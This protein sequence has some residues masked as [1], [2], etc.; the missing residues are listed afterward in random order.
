MQKAALSGEKSWYLGMAYLKLG[1]FLLARQ[2]FENSLG[3]GLLNGN[4]KRSAEEN[5]ESFGKIL[6]AYTRI[7]FS[8]S[9]HFNARR[10]LIAETPFF[11]VCYSFRYFTCTLLL[12][13]F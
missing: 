6:N 10:G 13:G 5:S 4:Q 7:I 1:K 2:Q 3:T 12:R 11:G 9:N 8:S